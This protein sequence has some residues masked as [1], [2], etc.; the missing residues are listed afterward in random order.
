MA[1]C[2]RVV[3]VPRLVEG[4]LGSPKSPTQHCDEMLPDDTVRPGGWGF[5]VIASTKSVVPLHLPFRSPSSAFD[6]LHY[7]Q[8][9]ALAATMNAQKARRVHTDE[10]QNCHHC[11][12]KG[13][14]SKRLMRCKGCEQT[15]YCVGPSLQFR[16]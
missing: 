3:I 6:A 5:Y 2:L 8:A 9:L 12:A 4:L 15:W 13:E 11:S 10:S 16:K 7:R 1:T 14:P